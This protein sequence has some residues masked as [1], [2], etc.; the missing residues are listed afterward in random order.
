MA[1]PHGGHVGDDPHR[2]DRGT[3]TARIS[4]CGA[5]RLVAAGAIFGLA[6]LH[7]VRPEGVVRDA[8]AAAADRLVSAQRPCAVGAGWTAA[9][10]R[11]WGV[12]TEPLGGFAHGVSGIAAALA[13]A[14][15]VLG[16]AR[17]L[18]L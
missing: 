11:D 3:P 18:G 17:W 5:S 12:A 16:D 10:L 14:A 13:V 6:A 4:P 8:I 2:A 7:R 1:D 15:D 9:L